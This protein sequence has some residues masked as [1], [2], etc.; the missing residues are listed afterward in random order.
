[1][2][3]LTESDNESFLVPSSTIYTK[4][5]SFSAWCLVSI[6]II[7][8]YNLY[9]FNRFLPLTEGWFS[10]YA[11][12]I[13]QG[14]MPYRDF[15]L[16][17]PPLYPLTIAG[18]M[19]VFGKQFLVLR[20]VG[21]ALMLLMAG[22]LYALL[23]RSFKH[24]IAAMVTVI[25]MIYFQSG[26]AHIPYDFTQFVVTYALLS[27]YYFIKYYDACHPIDY[28]IDRWTKKEA[29]LLLSGV[30]SAL[31]FWTKQS[32]GSVI[33]VFIAFGIFCATLPISRRWMYKSVIG[34]GVGTLI[35]TLLLLFWLQWNHA[36]VA[37]WQQVVTGAIQAKGSL[38]PIFFS[39]MRGLFCKQYFYQIYNIIGGLLFLGYWRFLIGKHRYNVCNDWRKEWHYVW[40]FLLMGLALFVPLW[41]P[42]MVQ[43][44]QNI[45]QL[46]VNNLIVVATATAFL[47]VL[48]YCFSPKRCSPD[49]V[50]T[51]LAVGYIFGGGTSAGLSEAWVF[52]GLA[53]FLCHVLS[54][55]SFFHLGRVVILGLSLCV[56]MFYAHK[57]HTE[58]YAWWYV[59]TPQISQSKSTT[60]L[61]LLK[62]F[63][64]P[65][66]TI[67]ILETVD[68]IVQKETTAQDAIL[69]FPNIPIFYLI[70]NRFQNIKAVVHWPDFLPDDLAR[71]E[72][73]RIKKELPKVI[74]YLDLPEIVW[75]THERLFR[76][77]QRSG[78]R[79]IIDTI[80][81]LTKEE[82]RYHLQATMPVSEGVHLYVWVRQD[83]NQYSSSTKIG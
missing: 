49:V 60:Q 43:K 15:Y 54:S 37:F 13:L 51:M 67:S 48:K 29:N 33:L 5:T 25:V 40:V 24:V 18:L 71:L 55:K 78:Q 70:E 63:Y 14:K 10:T 22:A 23:A 9:T 31:M 6:A 79:D 62:G 58:P 45:A 4:T 2:R 74:I 3:F 50:L 81:Q 35:P 27:A 46:V 73:Q 52:M 17:L 82:R 59:N 39:W 53:L 21:V 66:D 72:A 1:M 57:K 44:T 47:L 19:T 69:T 8:I 56:M 75:S 65:H 80:T 61:P 76:H 30:F 41:M 26:V 36:L 7:F 28:R 42:V 38:E 77:T 64:L 32:N 34:F 11:E 20:V 83:D 12:L 68:K 16:F